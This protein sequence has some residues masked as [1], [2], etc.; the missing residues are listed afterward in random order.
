VIVDVTDA[1]QPLLSVTV[2]LNMPTGREKVAVPVYGAVPPD[3]LIVI[4]ELPP[5]HAMAV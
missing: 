1:V 2:K 3:A 5:L 4:V